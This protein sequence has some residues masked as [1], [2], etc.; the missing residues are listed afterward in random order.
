MWQHP[1]VRIFFF[2]LGV[3]KGKT[4]Q[5]G[6][7]AL[8]GGRRWAME[9]NSFHGCLWGR[10]PR[11][12]LTLSLVGVGRVVVHGLITRAVVGQLRLRHVTLGSVKDF[13]PWDCR[14]LGPNVRHASN[15]EDL[16]HLGAV[17]NFHKVSC[18]R[19]NGGGHVTVPAPQCLTGSVLGVWVERKARYETAGGTVHPSKYSGEPTSRQ[20]YPGGL[21]NSWP[22][23]FLNP[24]ELLRASVCTTDSVPALAVILRGHSLGEVTCRE[25]GITCTSTRM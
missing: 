18:T 22:P 19:P 5:Q 6:I 15:G 11:P 16:V 8:E 4:K 25:Y 9:G 3:I 10:S 13:V 20:R 1:L 17:S 24:T 23:P 12:C 2:L 21:L 14:S 7:L